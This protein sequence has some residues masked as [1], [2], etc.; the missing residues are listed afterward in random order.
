MDVPPLQT[1]KGLPGL[2][3]WLSTKD[4]ADITAS[5]GV[6]SIWHDKGPYSV[7]NTFILPGS[8]ATL[9]YAH[10]PTVSLTWL[11]V[12]IQVQCAPQLWIPAANSSLFGKK[13]TAGQYGFNF[14]IEGTSGY[15]SLVYTN[16][17]SSFFFAKSTAA[18]GFAA[19][20]SHWVRMT[21]N[22]T[23]G[24]VN[25]YTSEDGSVWSLLSGPI[26]TAAGVNF[27]NGTSEFIVGGDAGSNTYA[28]AISVARLYHGAT[29]ALTLLKSFYA[30]DAVRGASSWTSSGTGET[31]TVTTNGTNGA[32]ISG[33]RDLYQGSGASQPAYDGTAQT[34]TGDGANDTM[35]SAPFSLVQPTT[36]FDVFSM[37]SWTDTDV[38]SDGYTAASGAIEQVTTTPKININA[39]SSV[40]A[41][42]S[43]AVAV[44]GVVV[45]EF[46]GASSSLAVNYNTTTSG[47]AG[48]G[49]M[50][51]TTLFGAGGT[52]AKWSNVA[53]K[54]H[55][56]FSRVLSATEKRKII[57]FFVRRCAITL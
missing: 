35:Q 57:N 21:R 54:E 50:G 15:L 49:N 51:G 36:Q 19:G 53:Y 47:N 39:G 37:V 16:D 1:L 14:Y 17:G 20:T 43:L 41:N 45:A 8:G 11:D 4:P 34:I 5:G 38:I 30:F 6:V 23:T 42:T 52:A 55:A 27:F 2:E 31:W 9:N 13:G 40:A 3:L 7:T 25:F 44:N 22:Q 48:A 24:D 33:A 46:N 10:A 29:G 26:A 56:L 12:D 18:T 28:G 32:R